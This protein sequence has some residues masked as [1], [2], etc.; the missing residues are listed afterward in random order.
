MADKFLKYLAEKGNL[1]KAMPSWTRKVARKFVPINRYNQLLWK[2]ENPYVGSD[3]EWE[4]KGKSR[5]T[6]GIIYDP[7]HYHKFYMAAC[8]DMDI[9]YKVLD[10]RVTNWIDLIKKSECDAIVCWASVSTMTLKEM[11]DERLK[12]IDEDMNMKIYPTAFEVWLYEN[13]RRVRDWL[14]INN[15]DIPETWCFYTEDEAYDFLD[16]APFPVVFKTALGSASHG[17]EICRKKHEAIKLV[18]KCFGEGVTAERTDP[19]NKQLDFIMFQEYLSKVEEKRMIRIGDTYA[20][21]DK[22]QKG[23][24]HSGSGI[25]RW[26]KPTNDLLELTKAITDKGKFKCMDVDFFVTPDG[27]SMVNE[28]QTFFYGNYPVIPDSDLRGAYKFEVSE[29]K[30]MPGNFNRNSYCNLRLEKLLSE[31]NEDKVELSKWYDLPGY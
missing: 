2:S 14:M 9:S 7:A 4:Y 18:K 28:L 8:L 6:I 3:K 24:F 12:F 30:F 20:C 29:W 23:D 5:N 17:V 13:K 19:R 22:I 25:Q 31:L 10:I 21:I 27:R 16:K 15:F 1:R 11:T 26:G